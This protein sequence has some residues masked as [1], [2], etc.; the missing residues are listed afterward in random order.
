MSKY[1]TLWEMDMSKIPTDPKES[2]AVMTKMIEMTKQ[3]LKDNPGTEWGTFIG[4]N[5][6]YV[7][8]GKS[9][10][11]VMKTTL[12]FS[13]YVQFKVYQAASINEVEEVYKSMMP[14]K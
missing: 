6:G 10:Q 2:S 14:K 4:E 9:P 11:D 13:P 1:V 7:L 12:M 3:W 8:G 5:K